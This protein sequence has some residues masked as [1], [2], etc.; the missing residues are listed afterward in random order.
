M[1]LVGTEPFWAADV[2]S[3]R[4]TLSGVDRPTLAAA[5]D[6]KRSSV[7]PGGA[8]YLAA[9][10]EG[11]G[12]ASLAVAL[13]PGPCSD[14]MSDRR[15]PFTASVSV[16]RVGGGPAELLKGCGAPPD[17]FATGS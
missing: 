7:G 1:R 17:A 6:W 9:P 10:V 11:A 4:I 13:E 16:T 15:Y 12:V 8:R 14:G 2:T 5:I 3:S